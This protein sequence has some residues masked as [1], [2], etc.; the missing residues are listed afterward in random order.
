MRTYK[1]ILSLFALFVAGAVAYVSFMYVYTD[2]MFAPL[3]LLQAP[4]ISAP[5]QVWNAPVVPF[6]HKVNTPQ[7]AR[8]K[9]DKYPGFEVDVLAHDTQLLAAHDTLEAQRNINLEAIFS[10]V[11]DPAQKTW[12]LDIKSE[13]S[14]QQ[15]DEIIQLAK[16]HNIPM[17]HLLFEVSA[18]PT[19][20]RITQKKLGLL[21]PLPDGFDQDQNDPETRA[22]LNAQALALWEE[23]QPLAVS[24]SFG[25]YAY[26]RAYFPNMQKAIYYSAT[27]RP[28]IKKAWMR[29]H[30]QKDPSVKIFMTDEY[31]W[32]NL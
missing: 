31:T 20:K 18:G 6:V 16:R 14:N 13:L 17:E 32:I 26:L 12:W 19:A 23:Y 10:A 5:H 22:K 30:M 21:L 27:Q 25:K 8:K 29:K 24:A 7:R 9:D 11:K 1:V 2:H 15:I 4:N 3:P 28:S